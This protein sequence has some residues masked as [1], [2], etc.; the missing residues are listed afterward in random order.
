MLAI[1]LLFGM[2]V[3]KEDT[4][5]GPIILL[6][7]LTLLKSSIFLRKSEVSSMYP[8]PF[9]FF[10]FFFFIVSKVSNHTF[11]RYSYT[12]LPESARRGSYVSSGQYNELQI[13][14]DNSI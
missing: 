7:F 5:M 13:K 3:Y 4:S 10:F 14:F 2:F 8:F 6:A 12:G 11:L 9:F 1:P